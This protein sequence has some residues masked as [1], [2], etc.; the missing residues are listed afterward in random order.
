MRVTQPAPGYRDDSSGVLDDI[1]NGGYSWGSTVSDIYGQFLWF[2]TRTLN[3]SRAH[4]RG[5]G[6][7][8]RC[9]SE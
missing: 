8:L 5:H 9:L 6:F 4:Y 7:Q 2:Y 3:P 1:G